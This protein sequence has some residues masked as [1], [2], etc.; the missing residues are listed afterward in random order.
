MEIVPHIPKPKR[1]F[2]PRVPLVEIVNAILYKLKTGVQWHQLPVKVLFEQNSLTWNSVYYHYRK[3]CLSEALKDCWIWC[4]KIHKQELNLASVDLNRSHTPALRGGSNVE[5]QGRKKRKTI[6]AHYL[7][8]RKG[9]PLAMSEPVA[10]NHNDLHNIE[11]Q[12]E[13]VT[14]TIEQA[15]IS[16]EGFFLNADADFDSKKFRESCSKKEINPKY[17]F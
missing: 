12:F 4:L 7:S 13:V 1:G 3:W 15:D 10:G 17:L 8:D 14:E 9:L 11:V 2:P 5:Y 6:N 16:V